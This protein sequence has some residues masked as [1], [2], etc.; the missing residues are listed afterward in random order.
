MQGEAEVR[1]ATA[2][3]HSILAKDGRPDHRIVIDVN[4]YR[5]THQTGAVIAAREQE[6]PMAKVI[7]G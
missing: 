2:A 4:S 3:E 1:R 5:S 6:E 7:Q